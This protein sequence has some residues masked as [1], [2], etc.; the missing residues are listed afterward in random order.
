VRPGLAPTTT[1][2]ELQPWLVVLLDFLRPWWMELVATL[3]QGRPA[4]KGSRGKGVGRQLRAEDG[5]SWLGSSPINQEEGG[6]NPSAATPPPPPPPP[7][8][9]AAA[10][11]SRRAKP[12]RC[13]RRRNPASLLPDRCASSSSEAPHAP[14]LPWLCSISA[15]SRRPA[16]PSVRPLRCGSGAAGPRSV[17]IQALRPC[18]FTASPSPLP[19]GQAQGCGRSAL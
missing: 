12:A 5:G 10:G 16:R 7:S 2:L 13:R 1:A 18:I 9:L 19:R 8:P 14:L 4:G 17:S 6:V 3:G 11:V 15:S